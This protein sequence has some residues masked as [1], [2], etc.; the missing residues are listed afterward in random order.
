VVARL[1]EGR[2]VA[3]KWCTSG[4]PRSGASDRVSV[5]GALRLTPV[6]AVAPA[7]AEWQRLMPTIIELFEQRE[8]QERVSDKTSN[9]PRAVDWIYAVEEGDRRTYYFEASRRVSSATQDVDQDT[10]PSGTL[11]IAVAGF[12]RESRDGFT[13]LGTKSELRWE[14]D[15]LPAGPARADLTPLGVIGQGDRAVWVM[16][17]QSGTSVWYALYEVGGQTR[18]LLTLRPGR[19]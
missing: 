13:S 14:Q 17:G 1:L 3:E 19:C 7:S 18:T 8:R 6:R 11:R 5:S 12:L 15:G 16:K 4:E 10:D 2:W 9:G